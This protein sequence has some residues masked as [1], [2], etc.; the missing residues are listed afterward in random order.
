M[1]EVLW[2]KAS[3]RVAKNFTPQNLAARPGTSWKNLI[4]GSGMTRYTRSVLVLYA[5][6]EGVRHVF[7]VFI[8]LMSVRA[9]F[10]A[11]ARV[12]SVSGILPF[13]SG[14]FSAAVGSA[15][16]GTTLQSRL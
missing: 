16:S 4:A 6:Q 3:A 7:K 10:P 5:K 2:D 15:G 12:A 1:R 14:V 8:V 13:V 9:G 11:K